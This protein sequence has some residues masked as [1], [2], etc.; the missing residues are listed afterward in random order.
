MRITN[1]NYMRT[2]QL[3]KLIDAYCTKQGKDEIRLKFLYDDDRIQGHINDDVID[4]LLEQ[5]G[6]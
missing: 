4:V 5:T 6:L 2:T 1:K 3:K